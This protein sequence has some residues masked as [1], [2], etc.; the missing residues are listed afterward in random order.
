MLLL[1]LWLVVDLYLDYKVS[2]LSHS[3]NH[4]VVNINKYSTLLPSNVDAYF[5]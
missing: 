3:S 4:K 2:Q 5:Q 1:H